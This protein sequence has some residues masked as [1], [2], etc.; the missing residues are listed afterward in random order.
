[1]KAII[2]KTLFKKDFVYNGVTY[3]EFE[4]HYSGK[5]AKYVST[6]ENQTKFVAGQEAEFTEEK[7]KFGNPKITPVYQQKF[8]GGA[9]AIKKEQSRYSGFAMAYAKD[10]VV[11]GIIEI[12]QMYV[13]AQCMVDW[14]VETDKNLGS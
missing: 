4:I 14:M 3:Y 11:A 9:R 13:E 2:D 8:S 6:S 5:K 1:M 7:D 10:L 12:E